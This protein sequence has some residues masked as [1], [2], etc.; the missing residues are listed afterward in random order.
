MARELQNSLLSTAGTI[1]QREWNTHLISFLALEEVMKSRNETW[2]NWQEAHSVRETGHVLMAAH[3]WL[4][5]E[6][7]IPLT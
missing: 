4:A 1:L 7:W 3:K 5:F 6:V 2:E